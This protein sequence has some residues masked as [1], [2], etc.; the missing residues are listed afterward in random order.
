MDLDVSGGMTDEV[1]GGKENPEIRHSGK[2]GPGRDLLPGLTREAL[3]GVKDPSCETGDERPPRPHGEPTSDGLETFS[4]PPET[5]ALVSEAERTVEEMLESFRRKVQ[6][7]QPVQPVQQVQP[8][9]PAQ[10]VQ[11]VQLVQPV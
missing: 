11:P 1:F 3:L 7:A 9:Q 4:L 5:K 6:P 10:P 8:V 2:L